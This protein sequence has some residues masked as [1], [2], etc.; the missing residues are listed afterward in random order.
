[1]KTERLLIELE[2]DDDI[3][4]GDEP[5]ATKWFWLDVMNG[6]LYLHSNE[7]GDEVGRVKVLKR[8]RYRHIKQIEE[9]LNAQ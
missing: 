2:Y 5:D 7:L 3:M 9:A 6:E 1:M 4:H 8:L